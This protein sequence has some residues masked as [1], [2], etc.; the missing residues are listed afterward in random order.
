MVS[1]RDFHRMEMVIFG[2]YKLGLGWS[3]VISHVILTYTRQWPNFLEV[4]VSESRKS[5]FPSSLPIQN[6]LGKEGT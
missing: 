6:A 1:H 3:V 2:G 4:L 5:L